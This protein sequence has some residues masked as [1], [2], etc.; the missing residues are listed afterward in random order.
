MSL[1]AAE[2][3]QRIQQHWEMENRLHWV[4]DVLFEEDYVRAGGN[5]PVN[6]AI[7]NCWLLNW[8]RQLGYR[9]VP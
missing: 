6:W 9:T 1:S 3:S 7:L 8:V 5:A 2:F 4:R